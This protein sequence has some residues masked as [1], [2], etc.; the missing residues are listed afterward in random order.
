MIAFAPPLQKMR[1]HHWI[2]GI[3]AFAATILFYLMLF[4]SLDYA[5]AKY[6]PRLQHL[7]ERGPQ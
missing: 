7:E 4:K 2:T 1:A 5:G 6:G 3:A